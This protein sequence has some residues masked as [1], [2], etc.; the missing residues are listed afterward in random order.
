VFLLPQVVVPSA[1]VFLL[2][3]IPVGIGIAGVTS[4]ISVL[5]RMGARDGSEGRVFGALA[6]AQ[7][8][9]WGIGPILGAAV[10]AAVGIPALYVISA[11]ALLALIA[12]VAN[13]PRWFAAREVRAEPRPLPVVGAEPAD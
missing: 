7:N 1:L 2:C 8:L 12:T 13:I 11:A 5:T 10:A 3:R 9:G 6:S 4:S